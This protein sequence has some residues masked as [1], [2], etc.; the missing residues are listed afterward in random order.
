MAV[1][2]EDLLVSVVLSVELLEAVAVLPVKLLE[3]PVLVAGRVE[4]TTSMP[5]ASEKPCGSSSRCRLPS[6]CGLC[7]GGGFVRPVVPSCANYLAPWCVTEY[8]RSL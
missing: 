6:W 2:T 1:F 5:H 3:P 4:V 8:P 7:E